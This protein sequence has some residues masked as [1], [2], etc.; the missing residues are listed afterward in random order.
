MKKCKKLIKWILA[1]VLL[2]SLFMVV[3]QIYNDWRNARDNADAAR[4][5][6]LMAEEGTKPEAEDIPQEVAE[7][8]AIDLDALREVNGDVLGWI[9]IPGTEIAYPL[10]Q[11]EDNRFYLNHNWKAES[12]S[13][14]SIYLE[15]TNRRD[16][17]DFHTIIYGHQMRNGSMFGSLK[18][19]KDIDFWQ[20]HPSIY[21]ALDNGIYRYDIFSA[22]EAGVRSVVYR[23]DKVESEL[24]EEFLQFCTENSVI[25][26][27]LIPKGDDRIVTLSTCTGRG[28]ANRWVVH[29]MLAQVY[30]AGTGAR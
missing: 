26:T 8:S 11:G 14:G 4:I 12:N 22:Q 1:V 2:V 29:G 16:M 7:L 27:G 15:C 5:A 3:R 30:P 18:Y 28:Y 20:E 6:G 25:D 19:Y 21:I 13:G 9:A 10:V 17:S 24:Q 23:T